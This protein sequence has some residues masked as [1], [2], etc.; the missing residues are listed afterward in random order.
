VKLLLILYLKIR[1][2][3]SFT[4]ITLNTSLIVMVLTNV[5]RYVTTTSYICAVP[6]YLFHLQEKL[7][8]IDSWQIG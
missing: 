5:S 1:K 8:E 6:K 4:C 2:K 7:V 3:L